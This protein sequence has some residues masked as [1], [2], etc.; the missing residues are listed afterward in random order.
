V[1]RTVI[2]FFLRLGVFGLIGMGVLDSSVLFLPFGNDLLVVVLTARQPERFWLFALAA[3]A[4]SLLGCTITDY[5]SRKIGEKGVEKMADPK[6]LAKISQ[7]LKKHTF[8]AL[9]TAA[10]MPPP[11]PFTVFLMAASALQISRKRVLLGVG[12]GRLVRFII[13][14]AL[15]R[16]YGTQILALLKREEVKYVV[17]GLAVISVAGS[18]LSIRRWWQSSR[19][20]RGGVTPGQQVP[21][22]TA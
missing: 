14:A 19:G 4:G 12:A 8:W 3:T 10:L 15:A 1:V 21:T 22:P 6:K 17:L 5:L 7:K 11:F 9:G 2:R 16:V 13:I 20:E 18:I